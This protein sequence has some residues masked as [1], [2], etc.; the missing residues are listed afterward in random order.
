MVDGTVGGGWVWALGKW[1]QGG[2]AQLQVRG[3]WQTLV[4]VAE[5]GCVA[6]AQHRSLGWVV[7][8]RKGAP[9]A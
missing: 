4:G 1:G 8:V 5:A 6:I 9:L 2:R 3:A 7:S